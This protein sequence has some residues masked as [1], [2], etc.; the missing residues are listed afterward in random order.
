MR[1][2]DL[3]LS[4]S[5]MLESACLTDQP[6]G[7]G[8]GIARAWLPLVVCSGVMELTWLLPVPLPPRLAEDRRRP[9][10]AGTH[11]TYSHQR[12]SMPD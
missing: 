11:R 7:M 6:S 1:G 3:L 5:L 4:K 10:D 2:Q 12:G 9:P 8:D